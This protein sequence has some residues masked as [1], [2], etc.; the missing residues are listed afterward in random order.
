MKVTIPVE[1]GTAE[2]DF[3]TSKVK[4]MTPDGSYLSSMAVYKAINEHR[5]KCHTI[6]VYRPPMISPYYLYL[7]GVNITGN[8]QWYQL[9]PEKVYLC[10]NGG[11]QTEDCVGCKQ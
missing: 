6:R 11:L 3:E 2:I 5:N 4:V 10:C 8:I 9:E 1:H 7:Q